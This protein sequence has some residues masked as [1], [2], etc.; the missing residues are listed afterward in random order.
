M[1]TAK[2]KLHQWPPHQKYV[3]LQIQWEHTPAI[4]DLY[5][6]PPRP[7]KQTYLFVGINFINL[8]YLKFRWLHIIG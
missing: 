7:S 5:D 6:I 1:G 2:S 4:S 8:S 3:L